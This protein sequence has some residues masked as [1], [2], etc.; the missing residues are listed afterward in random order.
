MNKSKTR[1]AWVPPGNALY[2][3]YHDTEW[4]VPVHDDQKHFE[5]LILEG[6]QAGLSWLTVLKRRVAYRKAFSDFDPHEVAQF[7]SKKIENL[8]ENEE[9]IRNR[10]KIESAVNNA[11]QFIEVQKEFGTFDEY[12]WS[13]VGGETLQNKWKTVKEIAPK[14]DESIALSKDLQKRGF[15]FVGPTIIYAH[16][17]AVGMVNDHTLDCFRHSQL[18]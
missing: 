3:A 18:R 15:K 17:Q 5:F 1:C 6:A 7:D 14:T 16:M 12:I 4:G 2:E 9:I 11:K 13:F 8:L 10:L